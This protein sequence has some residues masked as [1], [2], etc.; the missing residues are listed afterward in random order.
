MRILIVCML[1][2]QFGFPAF[3]QEIPEPTAW[4]GKFDLSK[5]QLECLEALG[6]EAA[7]KQISDRLLSTYSAESPPEAVVMLSA[8]LLG[9]D[10]GEGGGWFGPAAKKHDWSWLAKRFHLEE[11]EAVLPSDIS[12]QQLFYRLDRNGDK[13][14]DPSDL[15]WSPGGQWVR[16][17]EMMTN[18][19]R[20]VDM[21][22][23]KALTKEEWN[24]AYDGIAKGNERLDL[25]GYLRAFPLGKAH[26]YRMGD[27]PTQE[28]LIRGFFANELGSH[29]EG[30]KIGERAPDFELSTF[31]HTEK[32]RLNDRL[33][34]KPVVLIFGNYTCGPFRHTFP[35][36]DLIAKRYSDQVQFL[37]VYVREAH[38]EDGWA[39]Q[40]NSTHGVKLLQP[41]TLAERE[42]VAQT[43]STNL[44]YSF[45]LLVD[46]LED[47]VGNAYSGMPA[48]AYL[49]DADGTVIYKSGRGPFGF[50]PG[51][52]E[53]AILLKLLDQ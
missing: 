7:C 18:L 11:F 40:S 46:T 39:M 47:T 32:V 33:S 20:M 29:S 2:F 49:I 41:K 21:N 23:D 3:G 13:L 50:I 19:F 52:L 22:G 36:Y 26:G 4:P 30:P 51:E 44:K 15:D 16:E 25:D 48:R 17:A 43:C 12:D 37:G 9:D 28:R 6:D 42:T 1:L 31:D 35:E 8:I 24:R 45:P 38:P 10:M 53:Q 34:K 5:L 14:I 27:E